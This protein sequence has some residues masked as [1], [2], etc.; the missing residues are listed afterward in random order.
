M[1]LRP[2]SILTLTLALSPGPAGAQTGGAFDPSGYIHQQESQAAEKSQQLVSRAIF[3]ING[4]RFQKF[5]SN[6]GSVFLPS[7]GETPELHDEFALCP[8]HLQLMTEVLPMRENLSIDKQVKSFEP[9]IIALIQK[10]VEGKI[11]SP[12]QVIENPDG[13][14]SEVR[15]K[16][17]DGR[18]GKAPGQTADGELKTTQKSSDK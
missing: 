17:Y 11:R 16:E 10:C 18:T 9:K 1:A 15:A 2:I 3:R 6:V 4:H 5:Q 7:S 14:I 12:V 8:Q 13:S